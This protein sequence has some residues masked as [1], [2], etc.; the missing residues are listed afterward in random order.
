MQRSPN[1]AR[2][3][4]QL[5]SGR[6]NYIS[7]P[8]TAAPEAWQDLGDCWCSIGG[9]DIRLTVKTGYAIY[10]THF[11]IEHIQASATPE[12]GTAPRE[13]EIWAIFA[14]LSPDEYADKG[15]WNLIGASPIAPGM[16]RVGTVK[17]DVRVGVGQV[18]IFELEFNQGRMLRSTDEVTVRVLSNHGADTTCL[19]RVMLFGEP[20]VPH[21][22]PVRLD[23]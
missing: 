13:V 10:P 12:S 18:Q 19:Y 5:L 11:A 23:G 15:I 8:P 3:Q 4:W 6:V 20:L 14:H 2:R 16:G 1:W 21:P 17:Y 7:N 22:I 9:E